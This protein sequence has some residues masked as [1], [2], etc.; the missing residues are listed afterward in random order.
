MDKK[1]KK[2]KFNKKC[3]IIAVAIMAV[4]IFATQSPQPKACTMEAKLCP[5]GSAVGRVPPNCDFAPC[6]DECKCPEGYIQEGDVCNPACYYSTPKC[7]MPSIACDK[8][9]EDSSDCIGAECCHPTSCINKAYRGVCNMLCTQVCQGP[10]ECG[11]GSCV[12]I[13]HRCTVMPQ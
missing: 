3:I 12:C 1:R 2:A 4:A 6:P 5:D 8:F 7:L 13:D 11:T 10:L 9:C